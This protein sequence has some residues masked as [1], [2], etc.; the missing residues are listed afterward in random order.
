MDTNLTS[1]HDLRLLNLRDRPIF[2]ADA[3]EKRYIHQL[4]H[5]TQNAV[6]ESLTA[7]QAWQLQGDCPYLNHSCFVGAVDG[8]CQPETLAISGLL[9][10]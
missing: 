10:A 8:A 7:S 5:I 4:I 1:L 9:S 2:D 3:H 6:D